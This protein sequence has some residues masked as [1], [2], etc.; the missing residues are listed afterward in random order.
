MCKSIDPFAV[1]FLV[2]GFQDRSFIPV[3]IIV[4][5]LS[6]FGGKEGLYAVVVDREVEHS[7][8]SIAEAVSSASPRERLEKAALALSHLCTRSP[9]GFC[10]T[11]S[12]R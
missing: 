3:V 4:Q 6:H 2:R 8:S 1:T 9:G 5:V 11:S 12:S 10:N 7:L